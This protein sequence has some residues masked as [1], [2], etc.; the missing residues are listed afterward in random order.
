MLYKLQGS[1][2]PAVR[3]VINRQ[4]SEAARLLE[5]EGI[6]QVLV[7]MNQSGKQLAV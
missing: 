2:A 6:V 1:S 5:K 4:S 3:Q 7:L